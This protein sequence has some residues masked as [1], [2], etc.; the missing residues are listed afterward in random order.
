MTDTPRPPEGVAEC[1]DPTESTPF[2]MPPEAGPPEPDDDGDG[3]Q[4]EAEER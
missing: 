2:E 1:G 3:D 4:V